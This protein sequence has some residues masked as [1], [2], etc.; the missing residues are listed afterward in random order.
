MHGSVPSVVAVIVK[1]TNRASTAAK[2]STLRRGCTGGR[3]GAEPVRAG[4]RFLSRRFADPGPIALGAQR[5]DF[6]ALLVPRAAPRICAF[7][8]L[9][10]GEDRLQAVEIL[11]R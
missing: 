2:R 9:D 3:T 6:L 11:L 4:E 1:R 5:C 7:G 8:V 10:A